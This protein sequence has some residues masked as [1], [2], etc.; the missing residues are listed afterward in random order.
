MED[1]IIPRMSDEDED[2]MEAE[3]WPESERDTKRVA[4]YIRGQ[5]YE[6]AV[7]LTPQAADWVVANIDW[8]NEQVVMLAKHKKS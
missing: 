4:G 1:I 7:N 8:I 6:D 5:A 3:G 2:K